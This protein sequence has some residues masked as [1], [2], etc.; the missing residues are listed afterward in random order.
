ME[1]PAGKAIDWGY[2]LNPMSVVNLLLIMTGSP[3][4]KI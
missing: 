3:K 1:G 2:L 4:L